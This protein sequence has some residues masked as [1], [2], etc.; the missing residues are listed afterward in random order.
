MITIRM[1]KITDSVSEVEDFKKSLRSHAFNPESYELVEDE[2]ASSL[3]EVEITL[4]NNC[5]VLGKDW[6]RYIEHA[7]DNEITFDET[8]VKHR[9]KLVSRPDNGVFSGISVKYPLAT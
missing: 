1:H 2:P 5:L 4:P 3:S 7:L 9:L 8:L 6:D